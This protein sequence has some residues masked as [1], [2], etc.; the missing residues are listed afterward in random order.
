MTQEPQY[1]VEPPLDGGFFLIVDT[2]I[3]TPNGDGVVA[4]IRREEIAKAVVNALN[5]LTEEN[6]DANLC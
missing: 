6:K 1:K 3:K 2:T 5:S 4:M